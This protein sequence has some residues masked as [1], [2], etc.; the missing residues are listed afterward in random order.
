MEDCLFVAGESSVRNADYG[1]ANQTLARD[2]ADALSF[3][4]ECIG[5]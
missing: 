4:V 3:I 1:R 2:R 5:L